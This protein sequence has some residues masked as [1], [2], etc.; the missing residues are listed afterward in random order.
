MS[1]ARVTCLTAAPT[2]DIEVV[3]AG[4]TSLRYDPTA[5]Q[6]VYNWKT[7]TGAGTCYALTATAVDGSKTTAVF[8]LK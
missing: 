4:A 7:P 6:F 8:K 1:A 5:G 3:A 2:D